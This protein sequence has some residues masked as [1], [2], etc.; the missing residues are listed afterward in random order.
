LV[1][2]DHSTLQLLKDHEGIIHKLSFMYTNNSE[3]YKDLRQ[4]INY[5]LLK[6]YDGFMGNS[7]LSTWV[8]KVAM[9]T[10]LAFIRRK[11]KMHQSL[12]EVAN[13]EGDTREYDEWSNV[14]KH[15]KTLPDI[16]KSLIFLYLED[17]PYKEISDIMG[18]TESNVGVRLN[19]IKKKLKKYFNQ[20]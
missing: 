2:K 14:L 19:R 10:A 17:K 13:I 18:I 16:D 9:F 8:Y 3:E 15:I 12:D 20:G 4:E 1:N 5:Q 11:P 7:K 6:S